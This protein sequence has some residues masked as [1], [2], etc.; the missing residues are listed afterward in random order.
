MHPWLGYWSVPIVKSVMRHLFYPPYG[1]LM[2]ARDSTV[3]ISK[4][5]G[6]DD[7]G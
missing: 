7:R 2:P 5:N 4:G 3:G 1:T 6:L